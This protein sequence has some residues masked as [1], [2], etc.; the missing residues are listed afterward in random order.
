MTGSAS[1]A[2]DVVFRLLLGKKILGGDPGG[3]RGSGSVLQRRLADDGKRFSS[4][5]R[6]VLIASRR[7]DSREGVQGE[8]EAGGRSPA[9]RLADFP[10][11]A[12][13]EAKP[14]FFENKGFP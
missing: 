5:G 3:G 8:G 9:R 6:C 14:S 2:M 4:D 11:R 1:Q 10:N 7:E 13:T 12:P